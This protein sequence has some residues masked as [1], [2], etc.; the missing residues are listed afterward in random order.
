MCVEL[1]SCQLA[2]TVNA[3]QF[4]LLTYVQ[5]LICIVLF[6]SISFDLVLWTN[7]NPLALA[8]I[9]NAIW[10]SNLARID[11]GDVWIFLALLLC[12]RN[13]GKFS[14]T[15]FSFVHKLFLIIIIGRVCVSRPIDYHTSHS[16]GTRC[17]VSVTTSAQ[18]ASGWETE[19]HTKSFAC[20][21]REASEMAQ[22]KIKKRINRVL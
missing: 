17:S 8:A 6:H 1:N 2:Y 7:T 15:T 21:E 13:I 5:N 18:M 9:A 20:D 22:M 3:V 14:R 4:L 10:R 12:I 11:D 19:T 16:N